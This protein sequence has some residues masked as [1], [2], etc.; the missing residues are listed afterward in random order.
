MDNNKPINRNTASIIA[1]CLIVCIVLGI[2]CSLSIWAWL[3]KGSSAIAD[4][5]NVKSKGDGV[6]VSW[7]GEN[8]YDNLQALKQEDVSTV[9]GANGPALNISGAEGKPAPLKLVTGNGLQFFEPSLNRR[10]GTVLTNSDG[11]WHGTDITSDNSDGKYIDIDLYFRSDVERDVYLAGDSAVSP[12]S[13]TDR[14]SAYGAF[15]KDYIAAASRI[16]FL[17][18]TKEKCSFIWAPNLNCRLESNE[19]GYQKYTTTT[20]EEIKTTVQGSLDLDNFSCQEDG[21]SY[22]FWTINETVL[23]DDN[24]KNSGAF[25]NLDNFLARKFEYDNE[26]GFYVATVSFI[27][28]TYDNGNPSIPMFINT[29]DKASQVTNNNFNQNVYGQESREKYEQSSKGQNFGITNT[30]FNIGNLTCSNALYILKRNI[31]VG[32]KI[33]FEV[34]YNPVLKHMVILDYETADGSSYSRGGEETEVITKVKYFPL[35]DNVNCVLVNP[36]SSSAVSSGTNFKNSVI[37]TDSN[38]SNISPVSATLTEQFTTVKNTQNGTGY[39]ATFKFKNNSTNTYLTLTNGAVSFTAAGTEFTLEYK[40]G[41]KGPLLKAG[42]YY[43]VIEQGRVMGVKSDALNTDNAFT[44]YVGNTYALYTEDTQDK[45]PYQFYNNTSKK[46]ETLNHNSTPK[47]F[48]SSMATSAD[49]KVGNTKIA[50]LSKEDGDEY[51]TAHIV[52]RVWVEGTDREAKTPLA[53]GIFDMSL[54]FTSQ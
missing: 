26:R 38:K 49:V 11:S 24:Y 12:K 47:L 9:G 22:Y 34:A 17:D 46:L 28:P 42:E 15:S 45:Q 53:D 39:K 18:S 52:M 2:V 8:Y 7:D 6:Q 32:Q 10:L 23:I 41:V 1:K 13:T 35:N 40:D 21:N 51:Y 30:N 43:L 36:S 20:E 37:F 27:I 3:T 48:T 44:V 4:G 14:M 5:I 50:T 54:H 25:N 31:A 16:A 29:T 19:S 33:T